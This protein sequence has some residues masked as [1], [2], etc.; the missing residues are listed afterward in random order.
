MVEGAGDHKIKIVDFGIAHSDLADL[1]IQG[2]ISGTVSYMAPEQALGQETSPQTDLYALGVMLYE[3]TAGQLPYVGDNPL[4]VISQHLN[5]PVEAPSRRNPEIHA[6]LD[7]LIVRLM[8]KSP[9]DRPASAQEVEQVLRAYLRPESDIDS[10]GIPSRS[11]HIIRHNLPVQLTSFVGREQEIAEIK[12]LIDQEAC[13]L[14]TL[15]GP[16]GIGKSRLALEV[17]S[18]NLSEYSDGTYFIPLAA[19]ASADFILP[20]I[21][22]ALDFSIDTHSSEFD[23]QTQLFDY[24]EGQTVMLVLDNYEH[25][26][27]GTTFMTDLLQRAHKVKMLVTSRE[28]LN[29]QGEWLFNLRGLDYPKNGSTNGDG[30]CSAVEL[31]LT[32]AKHADAMYTLAED[33]RKHVVHICQLVEG[34]PLGIELAAV[35][36]SMLSPQEIAVEI[37]KNIDFLAT[38]MQN[39]PE[40]HRSVRAAFDYSWHLLSEEQRLLLSKL[41]VFRGGILRQAAE[42]VARTSLSDLSN[43]VDKSLLQRDEGGRYQIHELLRQYAEEKLLTYPGADEGIREIHAEYYLGLLNDTGKDLIGER[44]IEASNEIQDEIANIN[45]ALEWGIIHS[46]AE[47]ILTALVTLKDYYFIQGYF[48]GTEAYKHLAQIVE[49]HY[50][51]GYDPANPGSA[52]YLSALA[53]QCYFLS[54]LGAADNSDEIIHKILS[55]IGEL[56]MQQEHLICVECLGINSAMRGDYEDSE[57]YLKEVKLIGEEIKDYISLAGSQI[58]LGW[59]YYEKGNYE[60]C[61]QEWQEAQSIALNLNNRLVLAFAQSKLALLEDEVGNYE[62]AIK[63]QLEAR[64]NFKHFDDQAGIGYA[65]SR[66]SFTLTNMGEFSEAKRFG[67]EGY[68]SFK[69]INHRWG[70]P[71]SL[72]RIGFA[73]IGLGEDEQAWLHF[74]E[75]LR[76]ARQGQILSLVLYSLIGLAILI[77]FQGDYERGATILS[78]VIAQ[79]VTHSLYKGIARKGLAEIEDQLSERELEGAKQQGEARELEEIIDLVPDSLVEIQTA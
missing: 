68:Q 19:V 44:Q 43:L 20:A 16:G 7:D 25:L 49:N 36:I 42:A 64:E 22:E 51:C 35:W 76:L 67:Q 1:T 33:D 52:M 11:R 13:R 4:S 28:R 6:D 29:L 74:S 53:F 47:N 17:A 9:S 50:H 65:T 40:K 48:E 34:V 46:E 72:C 57:R 26:I 27:N 60:L 14:L 30:Q 69:E 70:V 24:L 54:F 41:S 45:S 56:N 8:S 37:E 10:A 63:I 79:P 2:E 12:Q 73:E 39:V 62:T 61:R 38:S 23:A 21:A 31:F 66:L 55:G 77:N 32:R 15:V 58:W 18:Q 78:F 5:A 75:A 71:A 3:L 59:V